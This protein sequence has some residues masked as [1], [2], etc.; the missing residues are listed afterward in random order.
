MASSSS[1][2]PELQIALNEFRNNYWQFDAV[3]IANMLSPSVTLPSTLV[4]TAYSLLKQN[5]P[6]WPKDTEEESFYRPLVDFLNDL[7]DASNRAL[8]LS[9]P[10]IIDRDAR[11][12]AGLGFALL[13]DG[14]RKTDG[15]EF[16]IN[17]YEVIGGVRET[18]EEVE[19]A[20][21]VQLGEDWL[22]V[23]AKAIRQAQISWSIFPA[24]KFGLSIGFQYTT[25]DL[26]FFIIHRGGLTA[27]KS[28]SIVEEQGK[29]DI[30]RIFLSV[31]TWRSEE[32]TGVPGFLRDGLTITIPPGAL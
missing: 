23:V 8:D 6:E 12:Y 4:A 9:N 18:D 3:A 11:W 21:P 13:I 5:L 30:L 19:V 28:L 1:L 17:K 14:A 26:R 29:K 16:G 31:L 2:P 27:S 20:I 24:R 22:T 7:F 10:P 32:D 15:L 25:L